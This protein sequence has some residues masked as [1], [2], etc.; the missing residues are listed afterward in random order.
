M[1]SNAEDDAVKICRLLVEQQEPSLFRKIPGRG[2]ELAIDKDF[3][4]Y[5]D[6]YIREFLAPFSIIKVKIYDASYRIIY[7]TE[8]SLI[9]KSDPDNPQLKNALAGKTESRLVRKGKPHGLAEEPPLNVDM[10][11]TYVPITDRSGNAV[12]CFE[13]YVNISKY[14]NQITKGVAVVTIILIIVLDAVFLFSYFLIRR[15]VN[16]L[17][18]VQLKLEMLAVTDMLT[19]LSNRG[20]VMN[21]GEKAFARVRRNIDKSLPASALSCIMLDVDHFKLVNDTKGHLAGDE[22]LRELALRLRESVRPYDIIGRYGGE[23]FLVLL[24]DTTF[25]Q[26]L[27]VADR[28]MTAVRKPFLIGTEEIKVTVSLGMSCFSDKDR[29]LSDLLSRADAGLY[30]AKA[31]GRDQVAWVYLPVDSEKFI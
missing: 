18:E 7:S 24:P 26:C 31:A 23:E 22:L 2:L 29:K 13:T 16:Q 8:A 5:L 19:G 17:K 3:L 27:V 12:G 4:Y 21:Y 14:K 6:Q 9:G 11:V 15:G 28:I 20:H 25:E 1:V 10:I 30:R